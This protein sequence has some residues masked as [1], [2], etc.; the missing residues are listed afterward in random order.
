MASRKTADESRDALEKAALALFRERPPREVSVREIASR[1][2]INHGLVHRYY[3]GKSGLVQAVVGR[4][5][6]STAHV[7]K[8]RMDED[9]E[10]GVLEGLRVLMSERWIAGAVAPLIQQGQLES[11]PEA[12][13]APVLRAQRGDLDDEQAAALALVESAVLGWMLFEPLVARGTGLSDWDEDA[14]LRAL[15]RVIAKLSWG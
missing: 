2:G 5:F 6:R 14:R 11:I 10:V 15:A 13:M 4:V 3:G 9:P 8:A 7:I 1:A 12:S